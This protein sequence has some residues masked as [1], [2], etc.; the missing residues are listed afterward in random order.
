MRTNLINLQ[1]WLT[2][3]EMPQDNPFMG[4]GPQANREGEGPGQA[5]GNAEEPQ[6][7][8]SVTNQ[9]D[10]DL[11]QDPQVPDMPEGIS[12]DGA[13]FE[14]W[15]Q[16]FFDLAIKA[17]TND[18]IDAIGQ[19]RDR[20]LDAAQRRFVEDNLEVVLF[21]QDANL[22]K[23]SKEIRKLISQ[24][25]DR[26]YPSVSVMQHINNTLE[27]YPL[28]RNVYIKM[29]GMGSRK[30]SYHRQ[31]IASL[32]GAVVVGGGGGKEDMIFPARDYS[33]NISSRFYT[34]FG[35]I[36]LGK[37][38]M[39]EDDP[40]KFLSDSELERLEEGSPEEKRVLRRRIVLESIATKYNNRAF[41][42]NIVEP[43]NGA[44]HSFAWDVAEGLR[45]GYKEGK[46]VVRKRKTEFRDAQIDDNGAIIPLFDLSVL[47]RQEGSSTDDMGNPK[48]DEVPFM[49]RRDGT[50]YLTASQETLQELAGGM[51]GMFYNS[52]AWEGNPSDIVDLMRCR[53]SI[54]EALMRRC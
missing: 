52:Q 7:D 45:A 15:R 34:K 12:D 50:L 21:R 27:S 49:E 1:G 17:D 26:N 3:A 51:P 25:L 42:I 23:A 29:A 40:E 13:D 19:V 31:F 20:Q 47:Y 39:Q 35:D 30:A 36:S 24:E 11:T 33:I 41:L 22:D 4:P 5:I 28:L 43:D 46:L 6:G 9:G 8:P 14:D 54:V 44:L 32:L 38:T 2:E 48:T 10:D 53:P 18:M 16:E 37:W